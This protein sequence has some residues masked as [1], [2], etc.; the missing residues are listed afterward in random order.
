MIAIILQ[1]I[2]HKRSRSRT[3][4]VDV[5]RII[6]ARDCGDWSMVQRSQLYLMNS[7]EYCELLELIERYVPKNRDLEIFR[8][9]EL[10]EKDIAKYT[11]TTITEVRRGGREGTLWD[12]IC[13]TFNRVERV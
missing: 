13:N 6:H 11:D 2:K 8:I 7:P 1:R 10:D 4:A 5:Q 12:L 3:T 9:M